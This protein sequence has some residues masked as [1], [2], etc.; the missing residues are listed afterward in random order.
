LGLFGWDAI[1]IDIR[2][3]MSGK[4]RLQNS[5]SAMQLSLRYAGLLIVINP[6]GFVVDAIEG[7]I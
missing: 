1:H 3:V 2:V 4:R 6:F 7:K 5:Y